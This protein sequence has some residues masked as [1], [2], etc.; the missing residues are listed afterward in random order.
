[1][2]AFLVSRVLLNKCSIEHITKFTPFQLIENCRI[3]RKSALGI[4]SEH[5]DTDKYFES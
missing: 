1:M 4:R 2:H 5:F 3:Y